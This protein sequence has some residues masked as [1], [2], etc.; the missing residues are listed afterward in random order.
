MSKFSFC[1]QVT[2]HIYLFLVVFLYQTVQWYKHRYGVPT[3]LYMQVFVC[4]C[5]RACVCVCAR[6]C[7]CVCVFVR[8]RVRARVCVCVCVYSLNFSR[9]TYFTVLPNSAQKH[10]FMDKILH[11]ASSHALHLL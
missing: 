1:T 3:G 9:G 10:V 11:V 8:V 5:A 7:V 4:V 6:V 2:S